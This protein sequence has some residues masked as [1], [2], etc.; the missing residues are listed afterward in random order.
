MC[1][2]IPISKYVFA[3]VLVGIIAVIWSEIY[4]LQQTIK[5]QEFKIQELAN[6]FTRNVIELQRLDRR[7]QL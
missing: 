3:A 1:I 2:G 6:M 7:L 5:D 4:K